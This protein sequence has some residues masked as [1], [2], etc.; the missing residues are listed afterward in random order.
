MPPP[1]AAK[2][3]FN[4]PSADKPQLEKSDIEPAFGFSSNT[5]SLL[6]WI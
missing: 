1:G 4:S 2:S 3:G 5:D 6:N